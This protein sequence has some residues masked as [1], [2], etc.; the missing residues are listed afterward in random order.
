MLQLSLKYGNT[1]TS[2]IAYSC[3]GL[4]L[5]GIV[6]DIDSGYQFGQ[7]ALNLIDRF[8]AEEYKPY[9]VYTVN[10]FVRHWKEPG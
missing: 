1:S 2:A 7:L 9:T 4:V 8:K 5:C 3:Y 6:G 10:V